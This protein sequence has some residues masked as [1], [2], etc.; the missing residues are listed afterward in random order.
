M[1]RCTS[2]ENY[3]INFNYSGCLSVNNTIDGV[4]VVVGTRGVVIYR[5]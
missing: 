4:V 1:W 2:S 5:F 3:F